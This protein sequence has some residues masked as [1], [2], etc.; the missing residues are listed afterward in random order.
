[1]MGDHPY[2]LKHTRYIGTVS[3]NRIIG[4]SRRILFSSEDGVK[5][6]RILKKI[7]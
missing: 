1:M 6:H 3:E 2:D 5:Y 4:K 7:Q